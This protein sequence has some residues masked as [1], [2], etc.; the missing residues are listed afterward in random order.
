MDYSPQLVCAGL[1]EGATGWRWTC[2]PAAKWPLHN[3]WEGVTVEDQERADDR[4][5]RYPDWISAEPLLGPIEF[6]QLDIYGAKQVIVGGESGPNA[7]PCDVE[8]IRDIVRQCREADVRCFVKQLGSKAFDSSYDI[9]V[10]LPSMRVKTS[11][12]IK[13][14]GAGSDPSEWPEDLRVRELGW[15]CRTKA[16]LEG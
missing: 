16:A 11:N 10:S 6:G 1:A 2:D 7:R 4:L 15:D 5:T 3:V 14:R 8:W 9:E 13:V 12:A